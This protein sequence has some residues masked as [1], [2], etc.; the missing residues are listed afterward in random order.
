MTIRDHHAPT[1]LVNNGREAR[2]WKQFG[3]RSRHDNKYS[4]RNRGII[5]KRCQINFPAPALGITWSDVKVEAVSADA[6]INEN[7]TSQFNFL[8]GLRDY[9]KK[10]LPRAIFNSSHGYLKPGEMLLVLGRPGSGCTTLLS[11]LANKRRG[12]QAVTDFMNTEEELFFPALAVGQTLDFGTRLKMPAHR[13][14]AAFSWDYYQKG[15][16]TFYYARWDLYIPRIPRSEMSLCGV[17]PGVKGSGCLSPSAWQLAAPSFSGIK[18]P[19]AWMPAP[20]STTPR[21]SV[22]YRH[23][24]ALL[25][26]QLYLAVNSIYELFHK[27]LVVDAGKHI[28][29][30]PPKEARYFMEHL[31]LICED[32]S[33]VAD[34]LTGITVPTKR[35]VSP[36]HRGTTPDNADAFR[37]VY[38]S[39]HIYQQM[40]SE[41]G[42]PKTEVAEYQTQSFMVVA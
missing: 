12:Y 20:H 36:E 10:P 15:C 41:Y 26:R 17:F 14:P 38:E 29:Y 18:A 35:K 25:G 1:A 13:P 23:A 31:G 21:L 42:Y 24:G 32:G 7:F 34:L 4:T 19:E 37:A 30:G 16:E 11:I 40:I 9:N 39:S 8:N 2:S 22:P 5:G 28:F 33:N 6:V 3:F 27:G